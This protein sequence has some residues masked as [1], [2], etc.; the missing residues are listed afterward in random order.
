VEKIDCGWQASKSMYV[1]EIKP[2]FFQGFF[3]S[4]FPVKSKWQERKL[5]TGSGHLFET[6]QP[7]LPD[8]SWYN[9]PKR[10]IYTKWQYSLPDG[11]KIYQIAV[12]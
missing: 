2:L 4:D 12:K 9:I 7:G 11:H 3:S 1:A 8:F 10:E 6:W 5:I